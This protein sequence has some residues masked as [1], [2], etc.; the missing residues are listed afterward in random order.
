MRT[1]LLMLVAAV[2]LAASVTAGAAEST[3]ASAAPASAKWVARQLHFMYS[4]VAPRFV[5][6]HYSCDGLQD[7]MTA[8][9]RQLGASGDLVV[10]SVGC[11]R[12][13]GPE[14]FPGVD[15][16]FSVLEPIASAHPGAANSPTVAARWEKVT[17]KPD[18]SCQLLDQVKRN[19]LP[20]FATRNVKADCP[21]G[22]SLEVLRPAQPP[23][24]EAAP[25]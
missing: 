25:H 4:P 1:R 22:F 11:T 20:L 21:V 6:T 12:A 17:F 18:T 19:V 10:R 5:T 13:S 14:P 16:R 3:D 8:I 24:P 9:L 7:Q 15:A 23:Q 2:G